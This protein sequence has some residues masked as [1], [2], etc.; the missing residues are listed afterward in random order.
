MNPFHPSTLRVLFLTSSTCLAACGGVDATIPNTPDASPDKDAEGLEARAHAE[1]APSAESAGHE[2]SITIHLKATTAAFTHHDSWSG[3]TPSDQRIG[4]R[5]LSLGSSG[6]DPSPWVVFDLGTKAVDAG[7]NDGD[8]TLVATVS[9]S[10]VKAGS[11]SYARVGVAYVR[12]SVGATVHEAGLSVPGTFHNLEVLS[13]DTVISGQTYAS[14]YYS[15]NFAVGSVTYG[16]VTGTSGPLPASAG[17]GISLSIEDGQASYGFPVA[18]DVPSTSANL[19]I[20]MLANTNEDFRWMD[21]DEP[22]Y[23]KGVFDVTP[24]SSFEPVEQFGA[25]SLTLS[26]AVEP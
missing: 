15:F 26:V 8:D 11:Y 25:N 19:A 6:A 16:P 20:T 12:Y 4:I 14:G 5:S 3:Q 22:G 10:S 2:G 13:D 9:A 7:L 17:L 18:L 23:T 24:P 21:Q 1:G